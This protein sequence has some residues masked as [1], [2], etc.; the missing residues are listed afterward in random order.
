MKTTKL[1][2]LYIACVTLSPV[3][4]IASPFVAHNNIQAG[5]CLFVASIVGAATI[6]VFNHFEDKKDN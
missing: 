5:I 1:D 4:F 2:V 6:A 3:F